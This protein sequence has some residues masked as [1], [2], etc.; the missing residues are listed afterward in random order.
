[1][2]LYNESR[3]VIAFLSDVNYPPARRIRDA[4]RATDPQF[5]K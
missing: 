5:E 4:I 3:Y 1:M 2:E